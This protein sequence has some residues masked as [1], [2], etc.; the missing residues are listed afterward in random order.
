MSVASL[1]ISSRIREAFK[2]NPRQMTPMLANQLGVPEVDVI[3][4]LPSKMVCELSN[5][6]LEKLIRRLESLG[7]VTVIVNN[8]AV[9]IEV[10][11]HFRG[12]STADGFLNVQ[13]S[14]LDIHIRISEL[15]S[16]FAVRKPSHFDG[17]EALSIQFFKKDGQSAFKVFLTFGVEVPSPTRQSEFEQFCR[18]YCTVQAQWPVTERK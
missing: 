7:R 9:A 16:V 1:N 13:S 4:H 6:N 3:R 14:D 12:F 17:V 18:E 10:T 2:Q 5:K 11:G 15:G 8:G